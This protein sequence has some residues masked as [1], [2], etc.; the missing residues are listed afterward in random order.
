MARNDTSILGIDL[1]ASEIR[2]VHVRYRGGKGSVLNS[3]YIPMPMDAMVT[4]RII[5]PGAIAIA[6]RR[7]VD[8][9]H[10]GSCNRA[11][12]GIPGGTALRNVSI[13]PVPDGELAMVVQAEVEHQG[14]LR[15]PNTAYAYIKLW[16]PIER[17]EPIDSVAIFAVDDDTTFQLRSIAERS[18]LT[19]EALEPVQYAMFRA[20]MLA[21]V[22]RPTVLALMVGASSTELAFVREGKLVAYRRLE[23]GSHALSHVGAAAIP[24]TPFAE[25][26]LTETE[27]SEAISHNLSLTAL[28]ALGTDCYRAMD[29]F[30]REYPDIAPVDRVYLAIDNLALEPLEH[31]L[32]QRLGVT[33]ELVKPA[34]SQESLPPTKAALEG[35]R[36]AAAFG[37]AMRN[38]HLVP[39]VPRIDLYSK[40]RSVSKQSETR[41]NFAGSIV[42]SVAAAALGIA[43]YYLYGVQIA[44]VQHATA[45]EQAKTTQ[46]KNEIDTQLQEQARRADQYRALRKEGVPVTAI[47]D[48]VTSSLQPGVGVSSVSVNESLK[49]TISGEAVD[50]PSL[51]KTVQLL[52]R[53]PILPG[54]F[55]DSFTRS[56]S[57]GGLTFQLS[58]TTVPLH[59]IETPVDQN[60]GQ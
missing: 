60:K 20:V 13:P 35:P 51:I 29:Y 37:L 48:Y 52:Q 16:S 7:L 12:I 23:T 3:G 45:V 43:G 36:F 10:T 53:S 59:R 42:T 28:D 40:E 56:E 14:V 18:N 24:A 25:V 11:V 6:L 39:A 8:E 32:T 33:V 38:A 30:I 27:S 34:S 9:M 46:I 5:E 4:D 21:T 55:I 17:P 58:A 41:R 19:I 54:L 44:D 57:T 2:V 22:D 47:L 31:E 1:S 26:E 15:H 50:E 49:V